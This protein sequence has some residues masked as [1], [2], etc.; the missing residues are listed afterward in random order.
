MCEP[1]GRDEVRKAERFQEARHE[2]VFDRLVGLDTVIGVNKDWPLSQSLCLLKAART[3][4]KVAGMPALVTALASTRLRRSAW[5]HRLPP[6]GISGLVP[7][8][9]PPKRSANPTRL[10]WG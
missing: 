4:T 7:D 5:P 9:N 2:L 10:S 3:E 6:N 1:Q 8:H